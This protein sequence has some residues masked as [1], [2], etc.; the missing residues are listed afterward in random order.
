ME[1]S[2]YLDSHLRAATELLDEFLRAADEK[3]LSL[4]LKRY[5]KYNKK[6]G[7]RDRRQINNIVYS[8]IRRQLFGWTEMDTREYY[9]AEQDE[10]LEIGNIQQHD[11]KFLQKIR[12]L[13]LTQGMDIDKIIRRFYTESNTFFFLA[14]NR[15]LLQHE[16][17]RMTESISYVRSGV[18]LRNIL[19]HDQF[20][21]QDISSQKIWQFLS[22][23]VSHSWDLCSG[24]GGKS[25][26]LKSVK[27][28]VSQV[29]SDIRKRSLY[30]LLERFQKMEME[31]PHVF[32]CDMTKPKANLPIGNP[33]HIICDVPCSGSAVWHRNP[34]SALLFEHKSLAGYQ[35]LQRKIVQNAIPYLAD[36]SKL[37]YITCSY[38]RKENEDNI[39]YFTKELGLKSTDQRLLDYYDQ[40]GDALFMAILEKN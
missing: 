7:K 12:S 30:N 39:E 29:C 24:S 13:E 14:S 6:F 28:A 31:E 35:N 27:P 32:Q 22:E 8:Q 37:L 10:K 2:K 5:F 26:K 38:F 18:S 17:I 21:V 15:E 40:N 23:E 4:Y 16:E 36:E 19:G 34:E 33:S 25:L 1:V 9:I 11:S 20:S 3:V